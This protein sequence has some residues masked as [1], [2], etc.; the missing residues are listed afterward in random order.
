M[1]RI[2]LMIR[3]GIAA[4]KD[5]LDF[6]KT[7]FE[8]VQ[9]PEESEV[10]IVCGGDG[11][12]F[13][14]SRQY[15][16]LGVP[17]FG[18]NYGHIGFLLNTPCP[19]VLNEFLAGEVEIISQK[20]LK[21]VVYDKDNKEITAAYAFNDFYFERTSLQTARIRISVD[22]KIIFDP[23]I[24]NGVVVATAAGSTAYS[25]SAGGIILPVGTDKMVLT[26][27]CP[28]IFHYW[29]ASELLADS[30]VTLEAVDAEWR[31]V[32]FVA[33]GEVIPGAV[34]TEISYS[35]EVVRLMFAKSEKFREKVNGLLSMKTDEKREVICN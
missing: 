24:C 20:M 18:L 7:R 27:I 25:A 15:R 9:N 29:R 10:I 23:L 4:S 11:M 32:V 1:K 26:G 21:A 19:R 2:Y 35:N 8:I 22:G 17:F 34:K 6:L 14:A 33:E 16:K 31:P 5:I 12:M 3:E 30:V 28:H 13:R